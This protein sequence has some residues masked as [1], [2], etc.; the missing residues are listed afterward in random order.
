[1]AK[2]SSKK[3]KTPAPSIKKSK[4]LMM[5]EA[6]TKAALAGNVNHQLNLGRI[7]ATGLGVDVDFEKAFFWHEKAALQGNANAQFLV[8][9]AYQDGRGVAQD[10]HQGLLWL[11]KSF[12]QGQPEAQVFFARRYLDSKSSDYDAAKAF[13]CAEKAANQ[14]YYAGQVLLAMLYTCGIGT[15]KDLAKALTYYKRAAAQNETVAKRCIDPQFVNE[16]G[17][18]SNF[19]ATWLAFLV[20]TQAGDQALAI[21]KMSEAMKLNPTIHAASTASCGIRVY[22]NWPI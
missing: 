21:S 2:K 14:G 9:S 17:V 20:A 18:D 5:I 8:G 11:E 10:E 12:Q 6:F 7:Y 13:S 22:V 1:M 19:A 4:T 15:E 16:T 3:S